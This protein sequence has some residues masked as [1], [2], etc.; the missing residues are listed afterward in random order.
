[1]TDTAVFANLGRNLSELSGTWMLDPAH[2]SVEIA[3]RHMMVATVRGR[4]RPLRGELRLDAEDPYKSF[5]DV[6]LDAASVDTGNAD[7]DK[8]LRSADFLDAEEYPTIGFR[9]TEVRDEGDGTYV[10][11]GDLT[12]K[13]ETRPMTLVTEVGGVIRDPYGNDR[14]GFSATGSVDRSEFGLT[15]NAA[16][17]GGGLVLGD[18]LK[19]NIDAEFTRQPGS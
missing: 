15:W 5:V 13:N 19:I 12:L 3:V 4:L 8:H 18:R 16:M 2:T 1:M 11:I 10:I 9:S 6:E 7:R 14:I 17:E